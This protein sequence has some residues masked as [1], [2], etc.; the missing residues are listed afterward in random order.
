MEKKLN[1]N[2]LWNAIYDLYNVLREEE[3]KE[4]SCKRYFERHPVVLTVLDQN[5]FDVSRNKLSLNEEL[6]NLLIKQ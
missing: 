6:Y 5:N 1:A 4:D 2:S 3:S